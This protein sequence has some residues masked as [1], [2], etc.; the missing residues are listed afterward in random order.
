MTKTIL[1]PTLTAP[2]S[3]FSNASAVEAAFTG[4]ASLAC[5]S[6]G[7]AL[8]RLRMEGG[9]GAIA[10]GNTVTIT[11]AAEGTDVYE[12]RA[13]TPP[14]GGTAGRIWVYNGANAAA[15]RANLVTAINGV[16]DANV[17]TRTPQDAS[18]GTNKCKVT[19]MVGT[20]LTS[21]TV[22]VSSAI[23]AA[24]FGISGTDLTC[25]ETL[26]AA[27][28]IWDKANVYSTGGAG[29]SMNNCS[30]VITP[31]MIAKGSV[32]VAV[33]H[34]YDPSQ[35]LYVK[36]TNRSRP[37]NEAY[38]VDGRGLVSLTLAGG[39]TPNNQPGDVVDFSILAILT[40]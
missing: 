19:A 37:Q 30:V 40:I 10:A 17:V 1:S 8:N 39:A 27:T 35:I 29:A 9:G 38:A 21:I 22:G 2:L 31:E 13:V 20:P 24:F 18:A 14:L 32:E 16:V 28:D 7:P 23:G 6:G 11:T 36:V 3:T 15:S 4:T 25:S 34:V 26:A 5:F 33:N 12:F